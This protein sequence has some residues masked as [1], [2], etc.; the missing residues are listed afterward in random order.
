[1]LQPGKVVEF[2]DENQFVVAVCLDFKK[3]KPRLLTQANRE[4][5]MSPRRLIDAGGPIWPAS[6]SRQEFSERLAELADRRQSLKESIDLKELWALMVE[7]DSEGPYSPEF[8]AG[9]IFGE[10]VTPDQVSALI[11]AAVE[12]KTYFRYRQEGLFVSPAERVEQLLFQRAKEKET[13]QEN[14]EVGQWLARVWEGRAATPLAQAEEVIGRL[15][16]VAVNGPES[17]QAARVKGYLAAA[18]LKHPEAAFP[19]LVKLGRFSPHENL[20]LWRLRIPTEFP[21]AVLSEAQRLAQTSAK[22]LDA[23]D[24]LDLTDLEVFTIDGPATLDF[25]DAI[26][27]EKKEGRNIV[28][29]HITDP[30]PVIAPGSPLD[31]EALARTSSLYLADCRIPMLPPILSEGLL[32][33]QEGEIRL[34]FSLRVEL[35]EQG[36]VLDHRLARSLIRVKRRL[37]YQEVDQNLADD[38]QMLALVSLARQLR[39]K[40]IQQGAMVLEVPEVMVRLNG[41]RIELERIEELSPARLLVAE[42]MILANG[43][44]AADLAAAGIPAIYRTQEAPTSFFEPPAGAD[45]LWVTLRQRMHLNRLELSAKP[46]RHAGMGLEAYIT[47]TSPIR[48]YLDLVTLRQFPGLLD[49]GAPLYDQT[50]L[51]KTIENLSPVL[52]AHNEVRFRRQRYWLLHYLAQEPEQKLEALVLDRL[53]DRYSLVLLETMLRTVSPRLPEGS[54]VPGQRI[55]VKINKISPAEDILRLELA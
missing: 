32:S 5:V 25:D 52:R 9:L 54:L 12:D 53:S 49:Q 28:Y 43:L 20:D 10:P 21:E 13:S 33:L 30:C 16:D 11:R 41:Q 14:N 39:Q 45:P 17:P 36:E 24:R 7:E 50:A 27:F 44:V 40:R 34:A 37:I 47:Y 8:L 48:R 3:D 42:L 46:G 31:S 29:I 22:E 38:P 15:I 26:S 1:L 23:S 19:L 51:E 4:V 35:D 6:L 55:T 18:G 2:L